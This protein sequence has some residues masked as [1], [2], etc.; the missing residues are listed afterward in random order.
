[1]PFSV[2]Q[3]VNNSVWLELIIMTVSDPAQEEYHFELANANPYTYYSF[4]IV[5]NRIAYGKPVVGLPSPSSPR[6]RPLELCI[7][8]ASI[9][10][11][12]DRCGERIS[13]LTPSTPC[14]QCC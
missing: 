4:R 11:T 1:M 13:T 9:A 8:E 6:F 2:Q 3:S 5:A 10:L 7:G 14:I 12:P